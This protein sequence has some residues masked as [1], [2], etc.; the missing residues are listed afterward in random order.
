MDMEKNKK[1]R[2]TVLISNKTYFKTKATVRDKEE[3]YIM[4]KG[5]IQQEDI[6]LV[7]I[8][9]PNTGA[10]KYVKQILTDIKEEIN[11][12]TVIVGDFNAP[13]TSMDRSSRQKINKETAAL[14][15]TLD[16]MDLIATSEHFIPKQ[17]DIHTF[18]VHMECYLQ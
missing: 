4:V 13:L 14:N 11:R 17:Q 5:T 18:Q 9:A 6:T 12:N 10:P 16:H 7:N 2:V 15:D 8:Y 3:H 1:A